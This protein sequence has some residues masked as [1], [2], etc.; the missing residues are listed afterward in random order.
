MIRATLN[1]GLAVDGS[2]EPLDAF[3]V[4]RKM[5]ELDIVRL[6]YDICQSETEETLVV[7]C[8]I[9]TDQAVEYLAL[10]CRQ[11][12]I[13]VWDPET[14][15]GR[16]VGPNA[17]AWGPFDPEQFFLSNGSRLADCRLV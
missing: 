3:D 4:L 2:D 6:H 9:P 10:R 15:K 1:V 14:R 5:F 8:M 17:D 12:C 16:L 7:D 11:D 13:A